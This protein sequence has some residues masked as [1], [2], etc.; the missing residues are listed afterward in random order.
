MKTDIKLENIIKKPDSKNFNSFVSTT[1]QNLIDTYNIDSDSYKLIPFDIFAENID[2]GAKHVFNVYK[3]A[4]SI[5]KEVE[6]QLGIEVNKALLYI[7]SVYHDSGRFREP[8]IS[9]QDTEKQIQAKQRKKI[10]SEREHARYGVAQI[11][12]WISKLKDKGVEIN[13]ED[14]KKIEN[15]ILNHDFF[16]TRLD[17]T[18]YQEPYSLEWQITRLADRISTPIEEEIERYR[19]TWKRL[20]TTYFK[21]DISFQERIDFSFANMWIYIKTWKFDEFT[22]FLS[23]LSQSPSD[24]SNPVLHDIY[25]KRQSNKNKWIRKIFEIAKQEWYK[26]E[27]IIEMKNMINKYLEHFDIKF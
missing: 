8:I 3:K 15:Y 1:K 16:N 14:Q 6:R 18:K 21:K 23:L 25:A 20:N 17:W 10:K 24:F 7:M 9:D 22:F 2:H 27:D 19:E 12:L 13:E 26:E 11:K 5:A 4:L